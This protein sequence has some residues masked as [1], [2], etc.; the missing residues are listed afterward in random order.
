MKAR[1]MTDCICVSF[2]SLELIVLFVAV[3]RQ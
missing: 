3:V 1:F 2:R